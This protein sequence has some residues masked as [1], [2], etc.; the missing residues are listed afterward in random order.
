MF[1]RELFLGPAQ[2]SWVILARTFPSVK[3]TL[4][5]SKESSEDERYLPPAE[6]RLNQ[7]T[8]Q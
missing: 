5:E 2:Q 3:K 8:F 6:F 7:R 1:C 4:V